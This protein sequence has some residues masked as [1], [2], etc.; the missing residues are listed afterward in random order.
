MWEVADRSQKCLS[1]LVSSFAFL[2]V[3]YSWAKGETKKLPPTKDEV[4]DDPEQLG[5]QDRQEQNW[6]EKRENSLDYVFK[7]SA[8]PDL[9]QA[10]LLLDALGEGMHLSSFGTKVPKQDHV[11]LN[12]HSG[13]V[14]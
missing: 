11:I 5:E 9:A 1:P 7:Y 3:S 4:S 6:G 8:I 10:F 2:S 14:T 13:T 12:C